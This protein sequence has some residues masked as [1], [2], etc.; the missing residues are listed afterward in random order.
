MTYSPGRIV[1]G[2]EVYDTK[3]VSVS[4]RIRATGQRT[5][6]DFMSASNNRSKA[7]IIALV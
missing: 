6:A 4:A 2:Q 7:S 1:G 3:G 5:V